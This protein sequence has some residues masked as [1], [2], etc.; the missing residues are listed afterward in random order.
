MPG[1]F[2]YFYMKIVIRWLF[3]ESSFCF[4]LLDF[5]CSVQFPS[6]KS[7]SLVSKVLTS[8]S[9]FN[10][11]VSSWN[12]HPHLKRWNTHLHNEAQ[13][14][15]RRGC[16]CVERRSESA[17]SSILAFPA[18][19]FETF[20]IL[21]GGCLWQPGHCVLVTSLLCFFPVSIH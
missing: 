18:V 15:K 14:E 9:N 20:S 10:P 1:S 13:E 6:E 21:S 7:L 2:G 12:I 19:S 8:L 16:V 4:W 3:F 11:L 5:F 17:L